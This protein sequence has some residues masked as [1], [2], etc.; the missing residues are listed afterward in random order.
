VKQHNGNIWVYSEP[1]KGTSF[2]IYLPHFELLE[3]DLTQA[4]TAQR[5][6]AGSET[7]LLVEDEDA[8]RATILRI[9]ASHGYQVL[10]AATPRAA[11]ELFSDHAA[12]IAL[13]L[14]DVIMPG[15]NGLDLYT[16]LLEQR[17]ELKALFV[18]GYSDTVLVNTQM[19]P[20][21]SLFIQKPFT[22]YLLL[23]K[24]REVLD[25]PV[26]EGIH[27]NTAR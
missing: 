13:L 15:Q 1:G 16:Q 25:A 9:L 23:E 2:K 26:T 18:S 21:G 6:I 5:G 12:S 14:S 20:P 19:L 17:P 7:I 22:R 10:E 24:V 8:V 4:P 27:D 11:L 3:P